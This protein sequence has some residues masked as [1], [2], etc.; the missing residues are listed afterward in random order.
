[1]GFGTRLSRR[2]PTMTGRKEPA[3]FRPRPIALSWLL[4]VGIDLFFNAGVFA[5]LFEQSREP[6]LLPDATLFRRIPVAYLALAV[7]ITALAWLLD[8]L[9]TTGALAG[10][11]AGGLVGAALGLL[12]VVNVWTALEMTG[13]FVLLASVVQVSQFALA[14]AFLG[15][16]RVSSMTRGLTSRAI[17]GFLVLSAAAVLAQNLTNG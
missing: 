3:A 10:A 5:G 12:G 4:A 13:Q 1:M 7:G 16:Y 9:G 11:T 8:R 15:A 2:A 6:S 14:G 17:V